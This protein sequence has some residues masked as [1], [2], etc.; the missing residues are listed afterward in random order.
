MAE[1]VLEGRAALNKEA[2]QKEAKEQIEE[3]IKTEE[4]AE[5]TE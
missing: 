1:A 2:E 4:A 5:V 3:K